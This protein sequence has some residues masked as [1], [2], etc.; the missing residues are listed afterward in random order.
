MTPRR[1]QDQRDDERILTLE[2]LVDQIKRDI[3]EHYLTREDTKEE[4]I[5]REKLSDTMGSIV[6]GWIW[7][8]AKWLLIGGGVG[9][10]TTLLTR[11]FGSQKP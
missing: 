5:S 8:S 9:T 3:E 6:S 4:F 10:I 7:T 2:I 11:L 1:G